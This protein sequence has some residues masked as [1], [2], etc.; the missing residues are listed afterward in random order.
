[1]LC[2]RD[3]EKKIP[4][5]QMP[6]IKL[7]EGECGGIGEGTA[8]DNE[9][10]RARRG[11]RG[12]PELGPC[13]ECVVDITALHDASGEASGQPSAQSLPCSG[14]W[15]GCQSLLTTLTGKDLL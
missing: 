15:V 4:L 1:M 13:M 8:K 6:E 11:Q 3:G 10:T 12:L 2:S 7:K 9:L 14:W 5:S